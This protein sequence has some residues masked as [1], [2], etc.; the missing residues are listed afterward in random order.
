MVIEFFALEVGIWPVQIGFLE[1]DEIVVSV[2]TS[3][4]SSGLLVAFFS[5]HPQYRSIT[6]VLETFS[7]NA[8]DLFAEV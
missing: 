1:W 2:Q 3:P 6:G 8:F 4:R 7:D 5:C